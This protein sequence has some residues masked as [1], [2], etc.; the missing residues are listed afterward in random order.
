[1]EERALII[2]DNYSNT[3]DICKILEEFG[4]KIITADT[5]SEAINYIYKDYII[6]FIFC[7][8]DQYCQNSSE[9]LSVMKNNNKFEFVPII[10]IGDNCKYEDI[11]E[12]ISR[13]AL[14]VISL[15][16]DQDTMSKKLENART[17][18]KP[19]I[20]ILEENELLLGHF[21]YVIQLE[22]YK[23]I[24][25][26]N[27]SL[28]LDYI[29]SNNVD[30]IV[31]DSILGDISGFDILSE[32]RLINSQIPV[33]MFVRESSRVT[34]ENILSKGADGYWRKP[35]NNRQMTTTLRNLI[36]KS[37]PQK[38]KAV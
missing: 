3:V 34:K 38:I 4:L 28:A 25:M 33:V 7:C 36:K 23:V 29:K 6:D 8:L 32:V 31:I 1:M 21:E 26:E 27:P 9:L 24:P 14:D 37:N 12:C 19:K 20:L 35:F 13:G 22:G 16:S 2:S 11:Q 5:I 30:V 18:G 15:P 17:N 10:T